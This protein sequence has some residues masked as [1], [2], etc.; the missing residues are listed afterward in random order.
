MR[1]D[2]PAVARRIAA[3]AFVAAVLATF[4]AYAADA[5]PAPPAWVTAGVAEP[6]A[7]DIQAAPAVAAEA[8]APPAP[9]AALADN[10]P[11]APVVAAPVV[12]APVIAAAQAAPA[13]A[14]LS[15]GESKGLGCLAVGALASVGVFVYGNTIAAA[16]TGG[17]NPLALVPM[18]AAGFAVGCTVGAGVSPGLHWLAGHLS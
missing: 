18:M 9:V 5:P 12:A 14:P 15:P 2:R 10:T 7:A 3:A 17:P 13:H 11:A 4:V 16:V 6:A 8:P 1:H